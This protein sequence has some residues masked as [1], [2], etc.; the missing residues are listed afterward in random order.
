MCYNE[1]KI[2]KGRLRAEGEYKDGKNKVVNGVTMWFL[3]GF[4]YVSKT[5]YDKVVAHRD[6]LCDLKMNTTVQTVQKSRTT[7][8]TTLCLAGN[9]IV[10]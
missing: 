7:G 4:G 3:A 5:E 9:N 10:G 6:F 1:F 8:I 2:K